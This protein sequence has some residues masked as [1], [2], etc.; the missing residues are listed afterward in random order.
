MFFLQEKIYFF[1]R[2]SKIGFDKYFNLYTKDQAIDL[3]KY[4]LMIL[5]N[6]NITDVLIFKYKIFE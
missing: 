5:K 6:G 4:R 1:H 3:L 2:F